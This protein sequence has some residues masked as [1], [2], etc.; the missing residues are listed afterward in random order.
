MTKEKK[1]MTFLKRQRN[2]IVAIVIVFAVLLGGYFAVRGALSEDTPDTTPSESLELLPGEALRGG[3]T[4]IYPYLDRAKIDN[5][6]VHNPANAARGEQYVDWGITFAYDEK[7]ENYYGFLTGYEYAAISETQ[8]TMFAA[9]VAA[10]TF[11]S[12][13]E[14]HCTDFSRYGLEFASEEEA[15]YVEILR[16][17]GTVNK[18]YFGRKNPSGTGYYVRSG[19]TVTDSEGNTYVRDSVYLLSGAVTGYFDGTVLALPTGML[20]LLMGYPVTADSENRLMFSSFILLSTDDR[21]K[22]SFLPM[23]RVTSADKLF[24]GSCAYYSVSPEGYFSS[25]DFETRVSKFTSFSGLEVMEYATQV[26]TEKDENGKDFTYY[27]VEN[28]VLAK[29]GLDPDHVAYSL[30][31][32]AYLPAAESVVTS[33]IYFSELQKDGYYYAYSLNFNTVLRVDPNTVDFLE[34]EQLDFYAGYALRMAI[35]YCDTLT[36]K[37]KFGDLSVS[38]VFK[39]TVDS[40][41]SVKS[42]HAVGAN[43]DVSLN[44]YRTLFQEFYTTML[45]EGVPEELDKEALLKTE[46][47]LEIAIKT[48][49]IYTQSVDSSGTA[50]AV[51]NKLESVTRIM[52]FYQYSNGRCL[53]TVEMLDKDGVSSGESGEFYVRVSRVEKLIADTDKLI[54]GEHFS[55]YDKE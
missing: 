14:A 36:V 24:G 32:S 46:P 26:I 12:R 8:L 53:M 15:T 37:G 30:L 49:V 1:P 3:A 52:R 43:K 21:L 51:T 5:V 47:L 23:T 41:Y 45:W 50:G 18:L 17:D 35:G 11:S 19:D 4:L 42:V 31:Y 20:D 44:Y 25:D 40:N 54:K 39:A 13:V 34:W 33:E 2:T 6:K 7:A 28:D 27:M 9:A 22:V 29:Y 38:E 16:R 48:P 55:S 10:P